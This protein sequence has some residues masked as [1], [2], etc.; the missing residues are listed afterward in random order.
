MSVFLSYAA[1]DRR[2]A[3]FVAGA[4]AERGF[5]IADHEST[6]VAGERWQDAVSRSMRR[7]TALVLFV[8]RSSLA[9]RV[10]KAEL[11]FALGSSRFEGRIVTVA[12]GSASHV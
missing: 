7:A 1:S 3:R 2:L 9:S 12:L 11:E 4:L 6:L 8:S 10:L 5:D